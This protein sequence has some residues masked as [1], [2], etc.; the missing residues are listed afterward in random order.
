N[1][2]LQPLRILQR[3]C[4]GTVAA[5]ESRWH[6]PLMRAS[7]AR[8]LESL[9]ASYRELLLSALEKCAA[10]QWGLFAHNELASRELGPLLRSR[11]LALYGA[12]E[13]RLDLGSKIERLRRRFWLEPFPLHECLLQMRGCYHSNTVGEPKLA[14]Q[15]LD[16]LRASR[17]P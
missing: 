2:V 8:Q 16:E 4:Q 13:E 12:L 9:E 11:L 17:G 14:R 5:L 6:S 1:P 10:G 3:R 15:W 7:H